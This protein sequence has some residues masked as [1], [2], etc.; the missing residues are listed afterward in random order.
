MSSVK[1]ECRLVRY[2]SV[3]PLFL[4]SRSTMDFFRALI[5]GPTSSSKRFRTS[6]ACSLA[7]VIECGEPVK[8]TTVLPSDWFSCRG[9]THDFVSMTFGRFCFEKLEG[10]SGGESFSL[11]PG[12]GFHLGVWQGC[13]DLVLFQLIDYI[14]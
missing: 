3:S 9:L 14:C 6:P 12:Q 7:G 1:E 11:C 13:M 8:H 10:P 4:A 5:P 2:S